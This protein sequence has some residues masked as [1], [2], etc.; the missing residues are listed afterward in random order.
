MFIGLRVQYRLLLLGF[1]KLEFSRQIFQK[2]STSNPTKIR[3]VGAELFRAD[4]R[5]DKQT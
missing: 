5:T 4:G 2:H 3:P 1:I